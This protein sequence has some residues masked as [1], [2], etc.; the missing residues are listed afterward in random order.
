MTPRHIYLSDKEVALVLEVSVSTISRAI[1]G[2]SKNR[3]GLDLSLAN[4]ISVG[5]ARRWKI[6]DLARVL[7]ITVEEI[8]QRLS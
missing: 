6:S 3:A 2:K 4:P 5:S 1:R 8:Q 7:G